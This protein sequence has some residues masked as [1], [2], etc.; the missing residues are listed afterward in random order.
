MSKLLFLFFFVYLRPKYSLFLHVIVMSFNK[1]NIAID[2]DLHR[3]SSDELG[4]YVAHILCFQ[5]KMDF[6][7]DGR[8]F[9]LE[10]HCGMIVRVQRLLEAMKFSPDFS[11]KCI[12]V[13]PSYVEFCTPRSNYG[14]RGSL[15]L[16]QNPV[17][18]LNDEQFERL[19]MD[20]R[21]M[22][23]RYYQ[24]SH[25][26]QEDIMYCC[27]QAL[28]LDYFDF[29]AS[30]TNDDKEPV[31]E[32]SASIMSRFLGLLNEGN[33]VKHREVTWYADK[34]FV[35]PKYL[36]EICKNVSGKAANYWI[37]RY[38]TIHIRRLLRERDLSFTQISD[39]FEFS[40][41]A[42]FSRF[43]QKNL[44]ATPSAFRQ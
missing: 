27:T 37:N 15:S 23:Y 16:F 4:E 38:V 12:Y 39:M 24:D 2:H 29:R 14:I 26:F 13:S 21:Y 19:N 18:H 28:F 41:P 43:V 40:S 31:S 22:E 20:F 10:S 36:S 32:Q 3:L 17:M 30:E 35:T 5:G 42:Y 8:P 25:R 7:F 33:Y 44:G 11:A 6:L 1:S 9:T 34:L